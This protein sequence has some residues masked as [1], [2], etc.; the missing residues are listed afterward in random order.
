MRPAL[1][2]GLLLLPAC[3]NPDDILPLHGALSSADPV[4]GQVVRLLRDPAS[5]RG[6]IC[7]G[8]K[9]F[10]ETTADAVG[11]FSFDV[12]RAQTTK[13]SGLGSFC[14]RIETTFAS[15][16]TAYSDIFA[17]GSEL[18]LPPFVDWRARPTR[19]DGVL[20]FEPA[21]P[22]P[23]TEAFEGDQLVHRA[24]WITADGGLA[25]A[26]DDRVLGID[27]ANG[28]VAPERQPMAFD[29]FAL[30]DFSG[31]VTLH[32]RLTKVAEEQGPFGSNSTTVEMTSGD[33][34]ALTGTRP[35]LSRG[36]PCPLFGTPCLLS[37][38][39]LTPTDGGMT[40]A[41]AF[42]LP[43]PGSVSGVVVRGAETDSLLIGIQLF[44]VD[45]GTLPLVQHVLPS[46]MWN[47]GV[48]TFE[49][50]TLPDG[51]LEFG[52]RAEPRFFTVT[53]D[54]G[55]PVSKVGI[56]FAGGVKGISEVSLFE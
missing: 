26:A 55:V 4:E 51:G 46:S 3:F 32:A 2:I 10:K 7:D 24:E 1:L 35:A 30:E 49:L 48:P 43:A 12:F 34:L 14:F 54:A 29:D 18:T 27:M 41:V 39:D 50:R 53:F 22:L 40:Q 5:T 23:M 52:P 17:L 19:V 20:R 8:A 28:A 47:S 25:W 38:G 16:S 9:P 11:N 15:G 13:L 6:M 45:G 31:V 21:A 33:T 56:G 44:D 36:L 42:T 37:D